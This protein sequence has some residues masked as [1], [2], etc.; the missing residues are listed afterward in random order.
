MSSRTGASVR[1]RVLGRRLRLLRERAGLTLESAAP[2]LYWSVSKLSRIETAQQ[3]VDVHG[4]KSMLDLYGV[5]GEQ[6]AEL[7]TLAREAAQRG[8]WRPYGLGDN[9]Y[10][11]LESE[12]ARVQEVTIG[13][14]PGLLQVA[15]YSE[16]LFLA[17]PLQRGPAELERE[18]AVRMIR[19]QRLT[20][21]EDDLRLEAIVA[22]A[23][24]HNPVGGPKVLREQ[25]DHLLIAAELD[26]VNL[27]VL[28]TAVG[29]HPAL[30]SGFIILNF[31]DFDEPDIGYVEHAL[32]AVQLEK[33]ED[34]A[35]AR[36]KF[37]HL[38]SHALDP[39]AS[40]ALIERTAE[41]I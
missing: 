8:W 39:A 16:A 33:E 6:W 15:R 32:G 14:V 34:V 17:S 25:L 3:L 41:Q 10:I 21:A 26:N 12:A 38:R 13:F 20:A 1:R 28:P 5:G 18:V 7:T 22:E 24:L 4:V 31:G 36:L 29:A 37:D 11:G 30:A 23:A 19:Q 9:S 2:A 35:L 40:L 27:Q